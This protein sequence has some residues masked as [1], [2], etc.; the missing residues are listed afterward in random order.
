VDGDGPSHADRCRA[1]CRYGAC[2]DEYASPDRHT[3]SDACTDLYAGAHDAAD[4][5]AL[6]PHPDRV[7]HTHLEPHV[8]AVSERDADL[9]SQ[10]CE[11]GYTD[12][13]ADSH[14]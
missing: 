6:D 5:V 13:H 11:Y 10:V 4:P 7:G 3:A 8:N 2:A 12:R 1:S 9:D 14:A